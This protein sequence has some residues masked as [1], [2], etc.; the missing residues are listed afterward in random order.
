MKAKDKVYN[1]INI[2]FFGIA[3]I[4]F[5]RDFHDIAGIFDETE[6]MLLLIILCTVILVHLTKA[7]RL[8]LALYGTENTL[9]AWEYL[10]IYCKVTPVSMLLP[11]KTGELFRIYCYGRQ[12]NSI[13]NGMVVVLLDRF[14]DTI[15]ILTLIVVMWIFDGGQLAFL[16]YALFIFLVFLIFLYY[17]V[18]GV[19]YFWK[20][21]LLRVKA[22][23][24][25]LWGLRTIEVFWVL[26]GEIENVVKGRGIILYLLSLLAWVI[27]IGSLVIVGRISISG[28]TSTA[29]SDYLTSA[30]NGT[31]SDEFREFV[32][33]SVTGLVLLYFILWIADLAARK[34]WV[35][36]WK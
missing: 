20:K 19:C 36:R 24:R 26:Y 22:S 28:N 10:K 6:P 23:E 30:M 11:F 16:T 27:E 35:H 33:I 21:Y 15:A 12:L 18:P 7:C 32:F 17:A 31:M 25:R 8:Y 29:I 34:R 2:L 14:M 9:D 5:F 13:L 4:W 1:L 3:G